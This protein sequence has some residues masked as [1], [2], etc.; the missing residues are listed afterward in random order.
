M[1]SLA[2]LLSGGQTDEKKKLWAWSNTKAVAGYNDYRFDCD[3][4]MIRWSEYGTNT[5][6]GW[7]IDHIFPV[8]LGG[9][10]HASN[11]RARHWRGNTS[12]GGVLG[13]LLN[14]IR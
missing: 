12:A 1:E 11:L 5:E 9:G 4:R 10:D 6:Y 13:G 3:G 8:A 2:S 7:H 14:S